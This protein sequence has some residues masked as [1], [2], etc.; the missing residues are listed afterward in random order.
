MQAIA[1][2]FQFYRT[3]TNSITNYNFRLYEAQN[4]HFRHSIKLLNKKGNRKPIAL[5]NKLI[6]NKKRLFVSNG[7]ADYISLGPAAISDFPSALP[8]NLSKFLMKRPA[9]SFAL[10]SHTDL[11]A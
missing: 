2:L 1:D 5:T 6:I 8:V 4:K 3:N 10:V 11:S 7:Y 9:K